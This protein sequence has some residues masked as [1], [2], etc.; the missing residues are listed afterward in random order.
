MLVGSCFSTNEE[1]KTLVLDPPRF[2]A[3][4]NKHLNIY[5]NKEEAYI[6]FISLSEVPKKEPEIDPKML[7][8]IIRLQSVFRMKRAVVKMKED[9]KGVVCRFFKK[10]EENGQ[11]AMITVYKTKVK[12]TGK[13]TTTK[14][15]TDTRTEK[16]IN[17]SGSPRPWEVE[18]KEAQGVTKTESVAVAENFIEAY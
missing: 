1:N 15:Q 17:P 7:A 10:D 14:T 5:V 18:K 11:T 13:T 12:V 3:F 6:N 16:K 8:L 9:M 2:T 4:I